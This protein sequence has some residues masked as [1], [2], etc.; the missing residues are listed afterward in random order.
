MLADFQEALVALA[1]DR[2]LRE[3]YRERGQ[4][5]FDGLSLDAAELRAL[6]AIPV[7][8]LERYARSL[9]AKRWDEVARTVPLTRRLVPELGD[10]YRAWAASHP[11]TAADGV[12]TPGAA[13]ALR[14]LDAMRDALSSPR[15][16]VYAADLYAFE[17]LGACSR[18][19]GRAR[20]MSS[21]WHMGEIAAEL[22]RGLLPIDPSERATELRF[23]GSGVRWRHA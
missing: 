16:A 2:G 23:E 3:R 15:H 8:A 11:M 1:T 20:T 13:E 18:A 19:D 9:V 14:A 17:V 4:E 12:L 5:A 21:R 22:R 6:H 10:R 7:H